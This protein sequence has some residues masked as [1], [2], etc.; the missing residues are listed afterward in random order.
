MGHEYGLENCRFFKAYFA[1]RFILGPGLPEPAQVLQQWLRDEQQVAILFADLQI[2]NLKS[3]TV[4]L[5]HWMKMEVKNIYHL[6]LKL[7]LLKKI[8]LDKLLV[9]FF[10]ERSVVYQLLT[11]QLQR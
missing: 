3:S 1:L 5:L 7:L 10:P 4:I 8:T 6:L 2:G 9:L 11:D